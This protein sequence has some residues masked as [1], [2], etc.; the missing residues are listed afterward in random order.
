MFSA[1]G[2]S[3][4]VDGIP[5]LRRQEAQVGTEISAGLL[6]FFVGHG[7]ALRIVPIQRIQ[8]RQWAVIIKSGWIRFDIGFE[9]S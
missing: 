7:V 4:A 5:L 9:F 3:K 6:R 8:G 1:E 2:T